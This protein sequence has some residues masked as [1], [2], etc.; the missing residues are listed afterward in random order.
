MYQKI[1]VPLDLSPMSTRVFTSG[2]YLA[3]QYQA[4]MLLLHV[5]SPESYTPPIPSNLI[6]GYP[7]G[8]DDL[9]LEIWRQEWQKLEQ[10]GKES[11]ESWAKQASQE[12]VQVKYE[13]IHGIPGKT[14]CKIAQ[15][16]QTDLIV[17]G[18]RGL[19]GISEMF[20]GS[21]S[22][23]VLHHTQCSLLV[24]QYN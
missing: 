14:I 5:L 10:Q 24:V 23:Y 4:Q 18:R 16:W 20:L 15:E 1:L 21:V 3:K 2:L 12:Q 19:S 9:S 13:Q 17:I 22:N 11:L 6:D 8:G 7:S